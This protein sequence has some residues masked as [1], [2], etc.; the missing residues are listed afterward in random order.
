MML[1]GK[2]RHCGSPIRTRYLLVEI[3]SSI[4]FAG[5]FLNFGQ[6][7]TTVFYCLFFAL[8]IALFWIDLETYFLPDCLTLALLWLGLMGAAF[9]V[10]PLSASESVL[11]ALIAYVGMW[12][13]NALYYLWR[14][15]NGFGGGDFKLLAALGAWLGAGSL[16]PTLLIASILAILVF[17]VLGLLKKESLSLEKMLPFGPF[18]V[19]AG[20][21]FFLMEI[22]GLR[23]NYL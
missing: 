1:R 4:A 12:S 19:L 7:W 15:R 2:C 16:I 8:L 14:K 3:L 9:G 18:L 10:L 17:T 13:I 21:L 6:S 22:F 5:M 23:M 20:C 11:G